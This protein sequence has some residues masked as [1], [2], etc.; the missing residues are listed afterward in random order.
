MKLIWTC[1]HVDHLCMHC[2]EHLSMWLSA[3]SCGKLSYMPSLELV[4]GAACVLVRRELCKCF[5]LPLLSWHACN[6]VVHK[7]AAWSKGHRG[8]C[9][10]W[11]GALLWQHIASLCDYVAPMQIE[12]WADEHGSF[13]RML[14]LE[15]SN[16]TESG[17][18]SHRYPLSS[19]CQ[20]LDASGHGLS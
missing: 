19:P 2:L 11:L 1:R 4:L 8:V 9:G 5:F 15:A 13:T 10:A 12:A 3:L 7:P 6:V 20:L 17:T 16:P 18:G 14:G